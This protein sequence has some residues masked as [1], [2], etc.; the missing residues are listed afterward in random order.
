[1]PKKLQS[2]HTRWF[3]TDA[4]GIDY[5]LY[6]LWIAIQQNISQL[7]VKHAG[8]INSMIYWCDRW[9]PNDCPKNWWQSIEV[10]WDMSI[11]KGWNK[12]GFYLGTSIRFWN[13]WRDHTSRI[14]WRA[15]LWF[16]RSIKHWIGRSRNTSTNRTR[17]SG[18]SRSRPSTV[19]TVWLCKITVRITRYSIRQQLH[20]YFPF[21]KG[22][23]FT[24]MRPCCV[25]HIKQL[26]QNI[27]RME[28]RKCIL[29]NIRQ[30]QGV[31]EKN[32]FCRET[33]T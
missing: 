17:R 3:S 21:C 24:V 33:I 15:T 5:K 29:K 7:L 30:I 28:K 6:P 4:S 18:S 22:F 26:K 32:F 13:L 8:S 20:C 12:Q 2:N 10:R 27:I 14:F 11:P 1:M 9:R 16:W 19:L 23:C 25:K 31:M